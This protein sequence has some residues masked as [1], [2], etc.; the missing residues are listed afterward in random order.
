MQNNT[1]SRTK[2]T[3]FYLDSKNFFNPI[4]IKTVSEDE[5]LFNVRNSSGFSLKRNNKVIVFNS[6]EALENYYLNKIRKSG[7]KQS[8][9]FQNVFVKPLVSSL[10]SYYEEVIDL[11]KIVFKIVSKTLLYPLLPFLLVYDYFSNKKLLNF[12]KDRIY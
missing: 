8:N 3:Y 5:V 11:F 1:T 6:K 4:S 12:F 7:L 9:L 10:Y 2:K